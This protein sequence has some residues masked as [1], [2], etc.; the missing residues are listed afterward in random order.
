MEAEPPSG[1]P[2]STNPA[3]EFRL[4]APKFKDEV[5]KSLDDFSRH[6][7]PH[8]STPTGMLLP[9]EMQPPPMYGPRGSTLPPQFLANNR[10]KRPSYD[11]QFGQPAPKQPQYE[12]RFHRGGHHQRPPAS[13]RRGNDANHHRSPRGNEGFEKDVIPAL[14][15]LNWK[16][17][18]EGCD[19][20][21]TS[22]EEYRR[23]IESH[24]PCQVSGC[25][26]V[27]H[28]MVMKKHARKAHSEEN[29]TESR[30]MP[31][32]EEIEQWKEERRKRFPTKQNIILRQLA[33]EERLK[34]GERIGENKERF[35]VKPAPNRPAQDGLKEGPKPKKRNRRAKKPVPRVESLSTPRIMFAGTSGLD[36]YIKPIASCLSLLQDYGSD[37]E[38]GSEEN[39]ESEEVTDSKVDEVKEPVGDSKEQ[40][41]P[42]QKVDMSEKKQEIEA[43]Q[44]NTL[45]KADAAEQLQK[46]VN[47]KVDTL[48][49]KQQAR[50]PEANTIETGCKQNQKKQFN[51]KKAH[52]SKQKH[53]TRERQ[54]RPAKKRQY[55]LDYSKLRRSNQNTMLEKLLDADIRHER[56]VL[57]QCVRYVVSNNYFG[58]GQPKV[59]KDGATNIQN[60]G[61]LQTEIDP[62]TSMI[63]NVG[64]TSS[65]DDGQTLSHNDDVTRTESVEF[66]NL[67]KDS[68]PLEL[69]DGM[70]NVEHDGAT[71]TLNETA[72]MPKSEDGVTS[73]RNVNDEE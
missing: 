2:E 27:G 48:E 17:W 55:L 5:Q 22:E 20:N 13:F 64:I 7:N 33:Q 69:V 14:L 26:F 71:S 63:E 72:D 39:T 31:S 15:L 8:F 43:P 4:P 24:R 66:S 16:L 58:V 10:R 61:P 28:P 18:C 25:S 44:A 29:N 6:L 70:A 32:L 30:T 41:L 46:N 52:N 35:P 73:E 65:Q 21:C 3:K 54:V 36:D 42:V 68:L 59:E 49:E 9:R 53:E 23:H 50:I 62:T 47:E 57:L 19:V 51:N 11:H 12:P 40:P 45:E 60:K 34:R 67:P 1:A 56:N 37:S 38:N